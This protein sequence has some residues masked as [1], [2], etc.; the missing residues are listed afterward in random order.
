VL[1]QLF[2]VARQDGATAILV[3]IPWPQQVGSQEWALGRVPWGVPVDYLEQSTIVQEVTRDAARE[4][5]IRTLDLLPTLREH[6]ARERM[7]FPYDGH[8]S[9]AGA[10][11]VAQALAEEVRT[12]RD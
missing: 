11:T 5:G 1:G 7:F 12:L 8:F 3:L 4:A 6:A 9:A 10:R 2:D